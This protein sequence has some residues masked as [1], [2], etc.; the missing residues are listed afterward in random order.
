[1][2]SS[3]RSH[4]IRGAYWSGIERFSSQI[5]TFVVIVIMSRILTKSDYGLVGMLTIFIDVAQ[6]V[7]DSGVTQALI[8]KADRDQKDCSTA[9]IFNIVLSLFFYLLLFFTAPLISDFYDHEELTG[10]TRVISLGLIFNAVVMVPKALFTANLDFKTQTKSSLLA[11][12]ISGVCGIIMALGGLGVWSIAY[13]QLI[14]LFLNGV[15]LWY[16][17]TWRPTMVFSKESFK[18]FFRFGSN[19]TIAGI[20]HTVY[21]DMYLLAIG[22]FYQAASLGVYTRAYQFGQLP[23]DNIG[24]IL[25]RVTYPVLC[26][27]QDDPDRLAEIFVKFLRS[28]S[29]I[30]FPLMMTLS[31]LSDAVIVVVVG[32]KWA[33]A[34]PLLSIMCIS[35]MW[36]PLDTLNLNLLQVRGRTDYFLKCE[37]RKKVF[38]VIITIATIPFGLLVICWGQVLRALIDMVI[39]TYYTGKYLRLGF[40]RQMKEISPTLFYSV[41]TAACTWICIAWIEMPVLKVFVGLLTAVLVFFLLVKITKSTD[42]NVIRQLIKEREKK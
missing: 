14:K 11:S 3:L 13:Y 30:V 5:V 15:L 9:F 39:D 29:F 4:V 20:I 40:I 34:G 28:I 31:V 18:Y 16:F 2:T 1:M 37:V 6:T 33:E 42:Y 25:Q 8:R 36:I 22:K 23:S 38:G 24:N 12:V 32:E 26:K 19:F 35:M 17:S 7:T 21:K 10:L 27:F 41:I